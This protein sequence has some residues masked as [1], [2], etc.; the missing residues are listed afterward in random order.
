MADLIN[1]EELQDKLIFIR[2]KA[3]AEDLIF[4]F[5]SEQQI[6]E[7]KNVVVSMINADTIPYDSSRSVKDALDEIFAILNSLNPS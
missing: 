2:Q 6:R 1:I 3:G 5:G 7:G 4:G